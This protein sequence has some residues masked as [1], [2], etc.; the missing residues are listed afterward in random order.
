MRDLVNMN[1]LINKINKMQKKLELQESSNSQK[2]L[3]TQQL[4]KKK[5]IIEKSNLNP[6]MSKMLII[7][8]AI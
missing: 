6:K 3:Q 1:F 2:N 8:L 7:F 5:K 4:Q